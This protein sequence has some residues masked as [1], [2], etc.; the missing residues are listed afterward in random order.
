MFFQSPEAAQLPQCSSKSAKKSTK[1]ART[2]SSTLKDNLSNALK[3]A[4]HRLS[5]HRSETS[6]ELCPSCIQHVLDR[7]EDPVND[8]QL[9]TSLS[10]TFDGLCPQQELHVAQILGTTERL[11]RLEI[12]DTGTTPSFY[13]ILAE[14]A[15][16]QLEYFACGSPLFTTLI[17]FL[18][19]QRHLLKFT[20]LARSSEA[21][22]IPLTLDRDILC[23]VESLSTTASLLLHARSNTTSLRHLEYVGG[24]QNLGEEVQAIEKVYQ[25]GPQLRSLRFFWGA[26]R[27]ETF[28][29][30]T[31]F[32]CI[33]TNT[34]SVEHLYLSGVCRNIFEQFVATGLRHKT[35]KKLQTL[36]WVP[37]RSHENDSDEPESP[38][39]PAFPSSPHSIIFSDATKASY[40]P[41]ARRQSTTSSLNSAT[42]AVFS[43]SVHPSISLN[44]STSSYRARPSSISDMS[45]VDSGFIIYRIGKDLMATFP[46]LRRFALWNWNRLGYDLLMR[47]TSGGRVWT[48]NVEEIEEDEW[49]SV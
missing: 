39:S 45:H 18:S 13:A 49:L 48:Y 46:S 42:S 34:S 1:H 17:S 5:A 3:R 9:V 29:D 36:V 30:V 7:S 11:C 19:I 23:T 2:G 38:V 44:T 33:A 35:W 4:S 28:L 15:R 31:R 43:H 25:L 47:T 32:F 6:A 12:L 27:T 37:D 24:G 14:R 16:F 26:G 20:Y 22:T 21:Q 41:R 8:I 10:L 40:S